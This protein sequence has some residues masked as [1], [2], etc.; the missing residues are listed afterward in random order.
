MFGHDY[1]R[2]PDGRPVGDARRAGAARRSRRPRRCASTGGRCGSATATR[3]GCPAGRVELPA[4]TAVPVAEGTDAQRGEDWARAGLRHGRRLAAVRL[5]AA[6]RDVPRDDGAAAHPRPLLHEPRRPG[7]APHDRARARAARPLLRVPGRL[8]R[9]RPGARA[10]ALPDRARPTRSCCGCPRRP[11]R[12]SAASCSAR[13][14]RRARSRRSCRPRRA[15]SSRSPARS[16]HDFGRGVARDAARGGAA[17]ALAAL[18]AMVVPALLALVARELD[19]SVL[20]GWAFALAAST[21]C[22]LLLLGIWWERLTARGAAAGLVVGATAA[23][24][25]IF[26]GLAGR[27][28]PPHARGAPDPAGGAERAAR[29]RDDGASSRSLDT[30]RA[31]SARRRAAR[32]ARA[33]GPRPRVRRGGAGRGPRLAP[34]ALALARRGAPATARRRRRPARVRRAPRRARRGARP[35]RGRAARACSAELGHGSARRRCA[36]PAACRPASGREEQ[37]EHDQ[38]EALDDRQRAAER[39]D[40]ERAGDDPQHAHE[41]REQADAHRVERDEDEREREAER[42]R[43][44]EQRREQRSRRPC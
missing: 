12:G 37:R 40:L 17:S 28:R 11:G 1:P 41:A 35:P 7:R 6:D 2:A 9:A 38:P 34:L 22:P 33:R 43:Q 20:V 23:T 4:G 26:T 30:P 32:A 5:L 21:F 10:R 31:A 16:T 14:S 25:A 27:P 36:T 18:G 13:S 44:P 15:C 42:A 8:R 39:Q 19:I 24:A 29:V 3:C